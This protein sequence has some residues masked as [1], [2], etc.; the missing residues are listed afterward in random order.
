M[1]Q[2]RRVRW[3]SGGRAR[4][5]GLNALYDFGLELRVEPLLVMVDGADAEGGFASGRAARLGAANVQRIADQIAAAGFES[6]A[7]QFFGIA[8]QQG[9]EGRVG[10]DPGVAQ[11]A[12]HV[13]TLADRRA[14]RLVQACGFL[15]DSW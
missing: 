14:E 5:G 6:A 3:R 12:D 10:F 11:R 1:S 9:R 15:H 8:R 13:Q 4:G 7:R 2:T